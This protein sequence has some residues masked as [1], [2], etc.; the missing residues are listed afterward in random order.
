MEIKEIIVDELVYCC[1]DCNFFTST[2]DWK[3]NYCAL[4]SNAPKFEYAQ[5]PYPMS[6]RRSDCPLTCCAMYNYN[7][8]S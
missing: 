5:T 8:L 4:L 6:F 7:V 2:D 1:D 3:I